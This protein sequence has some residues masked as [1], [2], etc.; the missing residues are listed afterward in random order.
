MRQ[1]RSGADLPEARIG[2]ISSRHSQPYPYLPFSLNPTSFLSISLRSSNVSQ[3]WTP[4]Y[5]WNL[6]P[7]WGRAEGWAQLRS[8]SWEWGWIWS[9]LDFSCSWEACSMRE[10]CRELS[11]DEIVMNIQLRH[12]FGVRWVPFTFKPRTRG[13]DFELCLD[14]GKED[15]NIEVVQAFIRS[16]MAPMLR[17]AWLCSA[18]GGF[19]SFSL[20]S[21]EYLPNDISTTRLDRPHSVSPCDHRYHPV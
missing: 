2:K 6:C 20:F 14:L 17:S 19:V 21:T 7:Q 1:L 9:S 12:G 3:R 16:N 4:K 13:F 15:S 10:H 11:L 8:S 5:A 18:R